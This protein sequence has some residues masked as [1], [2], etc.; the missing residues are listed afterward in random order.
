M[1]DYGTPNWHKLNE[2]ELVRAFQIRVFSYSIAELSNSIKST[3]IEWDSF[4]I[5]LDSSLCELQISPIE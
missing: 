3:L 1:Y 2:K 5:E 4:P